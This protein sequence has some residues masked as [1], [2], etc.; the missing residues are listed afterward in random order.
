MK[1]YKDIFSFRLFVLWQINLC[2]LLMPKSFLQE[3]FSG[4]ISSIA[5]MIR[6][7]V[8]GYVIW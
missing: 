6:E 7:F 4:T 2:G 1:S 3:D 5:G 8:E